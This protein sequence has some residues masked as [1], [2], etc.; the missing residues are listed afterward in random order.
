MQA[1]KKSTGAAASDVHTTGICD[2]TL[3]L[4]RNS[5]VIKQADKQTVVRQ[6]D[7]QAEK[8]RM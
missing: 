3:Q 2:K 4:N 6:A 1:K 8:A 5:K 7:K